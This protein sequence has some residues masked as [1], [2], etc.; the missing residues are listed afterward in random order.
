[1]PPSATILFVAEA[2]PSI[3]VL[4]AHLLAI[5]SQDNLRTA[6]VTLARPRPVQPFVKRLLAENHMPNW[7]LP[8]PQPLDSLPIELVNADVAVVLDPSLSPFTR[9]VA[10]RAC[11]IDW[12]LP[13][14]PAVA[15]T[16]LE[17]LLDWR[18]LYSAIAQ[19]TEL[20]ASLSPQTLGQLHANPQTIGRALRM[21]RM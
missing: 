8:Q 20:L 14:Q 21:Q 10:R 7:W 17:A 19:R 1:V 9:A 3:A 15:P 5:A 13:M 16:D 2:D 11:L 12:R 6:A 18:R 4:A